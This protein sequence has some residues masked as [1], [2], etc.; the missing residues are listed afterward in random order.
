MASAMGQLT[1]IICGIAEGAL[2]F[3]R[4]LLDAL[5]CHFETVA[6]AETGG[7]SLVAPRVLPVLMESKPDPKLL[8]C[9]VSGRK[10]GK[11]FLKVISLSSLAPWYKARSTRSDSEPIP[12]LRVETHM[13]NAQLKSDDRSEP[14]QR[15]LR[16]GRITY[17]NGQTTMDCI[18][19]NMNKIG[20]KLECRSWFE[21]P[22]FVSLV[23]GVGDLAEPPIKCQVKWQD[24]LQIGIEFLEAR[25]TPSNS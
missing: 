13:S 9:R 20:A 15:S 19:R 8:F 16:T 21:C 4:N 24:N 14:R 1:L 17:N 5:L 25:A 12:L 10:T 3:R 2:T 18:I 22:E 11:R 23:I 6:L 7:C